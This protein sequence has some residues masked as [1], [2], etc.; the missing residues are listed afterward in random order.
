M[1]PKA[2]SVTLMLHPQTCNPQFLCARYVAAISKR[3]ARHPTLP[4]AFTTSG[5]GLNFT[6]DCLQLASVFELRQ[7]LNFKIE[8]QLRVAFCGSSTVGSG[9]AFLL[10]PARPIPGSNQVSARTEEGGHP[11]N[12]TVGEVFYITP[13]L[14]KPILNDFFTRL[15][16]SPNWKIVY[17]WQLKF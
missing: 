7:G 8:E 3:R 16:Y 14:N 5:P 17:M 1:S 4:I 11:G 15:G 2:P 6:R 13:H 10:R 9:D 12:A